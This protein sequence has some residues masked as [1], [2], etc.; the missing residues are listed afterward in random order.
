MPERQVQDLR[1]V[2]LV[3]HG[4]TGKTSLL[5]AMLFEAKATSRL[6]SVDDGTSIADSDPEEKERKIT[7]DSAVVHC[8]WKGRDIN[9]V[10]TPGYP[11][12]VGSMITGLLAVETA[13]LT[14]GA[15]KGIQLNARR[16]WQEA[17]RA[18][19]G[20][21][22]VLTKMD[23]ENIKLEALFAEIKECLGKECVP[24]Q[25]PLGLGGTFSGV[26]S[27]L[28]GGDPPQ[29]GAPLDVLRA[30]ESLLERIV[31]VEDS[32]LERYLEGGEI[33]PEE[34]RSA[35]C[36]AIAEGKVV[37]VLFTSLKAAIGVRELLDF[38]AE[39]A[40]SPLEG[41]KREL[42]TNEH[43]ELIEPSPEAPFRARVFKSTSDPFVGKMSY[44]RVL[45]GHLNSDSVLYDVER[46][47]E[48]R[49]GT[50]LRPQGK[51]QSPLAEAVPGDIVAVAKVEALEVGDAL[52]DRR[53]RLKFPRLELPNPMVSLAV[54]PKS[55]LDEGR[56]SEALAK[57]AEGD[58]TFRVEWNRE[59]KELII[60]GMSAL[61]L[62]VMISRLKR[63]FEVEVETKQPKI[64]YKETITRKA[65]G[66][67]KHKKQ[68]GGRGQY[69]EVYLRVE[70]LPRQAGFEFVD[71]IVG[72]A[73]PNQYIPAVEKGV[74]EVIDKGTLAGYPVV[75]VRV[76]VCD[77]TFHPVDSSEAS[78]KIAGAR[79][80]HDALSKA[81]CVL[82]EPIVNVEI[83]IPN[84]YMGE[85]TG[86]LNSKR[87][88]IQGMESI[89]GMQVIRAEVPLAEI[90]N[91]A[92]E[93][94]SLTGGEA[95]YTMEFSR[96]DVVPARIAEAVG[97]RLRK[98]KETE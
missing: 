36:Q 62:D 51:E 64:P 59:T 74:R 96:F 52:A 48:Y 46:D 54:R 68:T 87:A 20:R 89:P 1:N 42:K 47:K 3:G 91:Y 98:E 7:I 25:A 17:K 92:T 29:E 21:I 81:G 12:F 19:L 45:S 86:D 77:G 50:L 88:R 43:V 24:F 97:E 11:D 71:E 61:H 83:T 90:T 8:T 80:F 13:I 84:E 41:K 40:P 75:D 67:H 16:A 95:F 55:R 31:E 27:V 70:P 82:L 76:A 35:L 73:V 65:E 4:G 14:V 53:L 34:T 60:S 93:L 22:L 66:H 30:R 58:P 33:S 37:P 18:G 32:L 85:I 78:F 63:R 23:Q 2:A 57:L 56:I 49:I 39:Y 28:G 9:I 5:E 26:W 69:G 72:G 38:I 10:D 15:P 44:F 79:A 6:G 94:R